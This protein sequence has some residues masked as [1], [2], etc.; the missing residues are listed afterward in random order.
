MP[1]DY[2]ISIVRVIDGDSVVI[3]LENAQN[4]GLELNVRLYGIDAP[5]RN[6]PYGEGARRALETLLGDRSTLWRLRVI[7]VDRY[8]RFVGLIYDEQLSPML[9]VNHSML[10]IG[11]AYWY[12]EYSTDE[13]GFEESERTA[14]RLRRVV[15]KDPGAERPWDY[16]RR[17]RNRPRRSQPVTIGRRGSRSGGSC[18][19]TLAVLAVIGIVLWSAIFGQC[20]G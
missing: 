8:E 15:W 10:E 7:E 13:W 4:A 1:T 20:G 18:L 16:R 12:K 2:P 3:A 11:A 9:S 19:G 14:R 6:Q 5:E 17:L